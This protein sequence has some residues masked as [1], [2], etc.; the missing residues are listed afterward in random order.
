MLIEYEI[1]VLLIICQIK[2][3]YS[4]FQMFFSHYL[5]LVAVTTKGHYSQPAKDLFSSPA[6]MD[7]PD[8]VGP[9]T[10]VILRIG[11]FVWFIEETTVPQ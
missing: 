1:T 8:E 4:E 6:V 11:G 7:G 9:L 2:Q 3:T 10:T 5:Q